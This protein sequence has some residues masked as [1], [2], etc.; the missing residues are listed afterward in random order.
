MVNIN[1]QWKNYKLDLNMVHDWMQANAGN[2]YCGM[3]A[4]AD[5]TLHFTAEPTKKARKA[6]AAYWDDRDDA[7]AEVSAYKSSYVRAQEAANA[8]AAAL[9]S[10]NAKLKALGLSDDEIAALRG[11]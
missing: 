3:S 6:I 5:L 8:A 10:A 4:D 11:Q 1:L 2:C 7:C 9:A